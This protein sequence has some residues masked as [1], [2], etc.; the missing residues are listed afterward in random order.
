MKILTHLLLLPIL[1]ALILM[2][3]SLTTKDYGLTMGSGSIVLIGLFFY[4][5]ARMF[6]KGYFDS[7][8]K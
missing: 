5:T 6:D 3:H 8:K 7:D 2:V 4:F 1:G